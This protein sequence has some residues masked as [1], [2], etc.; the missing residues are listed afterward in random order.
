MFL[1]RIFLPSALPHWQKDL[2]QKHKTQRRYI[3]ILLN[4]S[5]PLT[6]AQVADIEQRLKRKFDQLVDVKTYFDPGQPFAEQARTLADS[7]GLTQQ[8][9]QTTPLLV[10]PPSLSVLA[11]VV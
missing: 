9:W 5:H 3:V 8:Q 7:I 2:G 4:F 11:C 6:A 1:P 10:N